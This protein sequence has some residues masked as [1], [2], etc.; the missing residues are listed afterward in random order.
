[1]V[2][3]DFERAFDNIRRDFLFECLIQYGFSNTVISYFKCIYHNIT[4]TIQV[5]GFLTAPINITKSIRQG[6]PASMIL[7][8]LAIN[9]LIWKLHN[10]ITGIQIQDLKLSVIAYADDVTVIL[11]NKN[12]EIKLKDSLQEF[13]NFSGLEVNKRKSKSIPIG[14]W[15]RQNNNV[16]IEMTT[17]HKIL[18]IQYSNSIAEMK[19]LN[20]TE[21]IRNIK[22][23]TK[24][25]YHRELCIYRRSWIIHTYILSKCCSNHPP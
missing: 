6:C 10:Q 19:N 9:P 16:E 7:F 12:D 11:S 14:G 21:I 1:M 15:N 5:N 25:L 2:S 13:H 8:T 24:E 23:L 17:Q 4:A 3:L 20:W 18:G 22:I